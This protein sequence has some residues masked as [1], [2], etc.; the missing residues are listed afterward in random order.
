[1]PYYGLGPGLSPLACGM[2]GDS[3]R[4]EVLIGLIRVRLIEILL[5]VLC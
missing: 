3:G 2:M 4:L 5:I 1:M